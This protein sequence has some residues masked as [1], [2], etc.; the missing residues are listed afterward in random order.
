MRCSP[1]NGLAV[2]TNA[3]D[4]PKAVTKIRKNFEN[5]IIVKSGRRG[6]VWIPPTRYSK[7]VRGHRVKAINIVSA[8]D[9]FNRALMATLIA[10][11]G[12]SETIA[13]AC[14]VAASVVA[15]PRGVLGVC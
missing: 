3:P 14:N 9:S 4:L 15:S 10:G 1:R 12:Y 8:G 5:D 6:A 11:A 7:T 2:T 13:N